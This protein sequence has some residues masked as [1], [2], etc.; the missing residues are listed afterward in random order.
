VTSGDPGRGG[1]GPGRERDGSGR[2][3]ESAGDR[4]NRNF[5]ELLQEIRVVQTGV[6]ILFAFLLT[7]P[8]SARFTS[9]SSLDEG[10]Y[11][12]TLLSAATACVLMIAPVSYHR[13]AFREG[14]K[15]EVVRAANRL[16]EGGVACLL[17]AIAS[18]VFVV[19]DVVIG[20]V[21]AGVV[22][23]VIAL[24]SIALWYVLPL[25]HH[26]R[27]IAEDGADRDRS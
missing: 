1:G 17:V 6:Q 2:S 24:L 27:Q 15:P 5:G 10:V 16:A 8:F 25:R 23:G 19:M 21:V 18:A 13:I 20:T 26:L 11:V 3:P 9:I 22:S 12:V 4:W 14:R 7:L